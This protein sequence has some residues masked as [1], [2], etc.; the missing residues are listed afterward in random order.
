MST[1]DMK[2]AGHDS[3]SYYCTKQVTWLDKVFKIVMQD[4]ILGKH[5][6]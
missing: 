2:T 4:I 6:Q 1:Q 3:A 5:L